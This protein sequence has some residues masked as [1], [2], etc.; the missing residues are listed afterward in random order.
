M[1]G[2]MAA[3]LV[4]A[5]IK[6]PAGLHLIVTLLAGCLAGMGWAYI[7]AVLKAK[8]NV[9]IVIG[10]ILLNYIAQY[11]VQY[12][13]LGPCNSNEGQAVTP[14]IHESA[15]LP[16]LMK[17]PYTLN[18]GFV[19]AIAAIALI[20]FLLNKTT[21]GYEMRAV[22][23]NPI[24]SHIHGISVQ[25]NMVLAMA[26]SGMLAGLAG[27]VMVTGSMH[28]VI[29]GFS[30]GYGYN[31]IPIALMAHNNPVGIFFSAILLGSM[32]NGSFLMQSMVGISKDFVDVIQGLIIIFICSEHAIQYYIKKILKQRGG[33]ED[34]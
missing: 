16:V 19:L 25:K 3:A 31:G 1:V 5:Y 21:R 11:L 27:A 2:G 9:H 17:A 10:T 7:A 15:N 29:D 23:M 28:R 20:Y 32:R 24:A 14:M 33:K 30:S 4:G 18:L 6:L 12:L 13:V 8:R 34:V 22:G 26:I